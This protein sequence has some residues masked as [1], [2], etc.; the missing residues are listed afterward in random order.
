MHYRACPLCL[1]RGRGI[2]EEIDC[3]KKYGF[4]SLEG[5]SVYFQTPLPFGFAQCRSDAINQLYGVYA[6]HIFLMDTILLFQF[7]YGNINELALF[8]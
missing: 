7:G 1:F 4:F 3:V 2:F 6:V 8:F 5:L